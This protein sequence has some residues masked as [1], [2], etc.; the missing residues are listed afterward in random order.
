MPFMPVEEDLRYEARASP[1]KIKREG[2]R[3]HPCLTDLEIGNI[4]P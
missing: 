1:Y 3:G 2:A 4:G